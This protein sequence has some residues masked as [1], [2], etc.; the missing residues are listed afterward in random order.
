VV[1]RNTASTGIRMVCDYPCGNFVFLD[2][3]IA[4]IEKAIGLPRR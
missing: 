4:D 2:W 3:D 1:A